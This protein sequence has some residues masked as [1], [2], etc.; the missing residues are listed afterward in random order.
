MR[1]VVGIDVGDGDVDGDV[2]SRWLCSLREVYL[3]GDRD[4]APSP[5]R[6]RTLVPAMVATAVAA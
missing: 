1:A 4:R 6:P 5:P 3:A 2:D